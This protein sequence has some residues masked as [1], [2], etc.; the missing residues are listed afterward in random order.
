MIMELI[1]SK[2]TINQG[3]SYIVIFLSLI[4]GSKC[5]K[6]LKCDFDGE[7]SFQLNQDL[8]ADH[9]QTKRILKI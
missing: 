7:L 3:P 8:D 2:R 1:V 9:V 4:S 6:I 5:Q